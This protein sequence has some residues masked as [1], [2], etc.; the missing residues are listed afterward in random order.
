MSEFLS[1]YLDR[2]RSIGTNYRLFFVCGAPKSGTTW[3]QKALDAHAQIVCAGEGHFADHFA[4]GLSGLLG[5]YYDQQKVVAKNVYE[6]RP[7]YRHSPTEDYDFLVKT[8]ILNAFARL[9]VPDGTRFIGDKTPANIEYLR[10]FR[11]LFPEAK[12]VAIVRDGRDTLVSTFRHVER[13][14][15]ADG[16]GAE[17]EAFLVE[18]ARSYCERWV[19]SLDDAAKFAERNPGVLHTVRYEDLKQDFRGAFGAVLEFLGADVTDDEIARCEEASSFQRL[20][21][22]REAGDEDRNAFVRKGIV[23][24]W[25]SSLS[26]QHLAVFNEVGGDWLTRLGYEA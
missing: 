18:K 15:R 24:D 16:K 5:R 17:S 8:F 22:G 23:G 21:G 1:S 26:E 12:I 9:E 25:R 4:R 19:R 10:V 6:G 14:M 13:V 7:H 20:S 2:V 3:L 11:R